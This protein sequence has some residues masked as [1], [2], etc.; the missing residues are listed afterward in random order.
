MVVGR[1]GDELFQERI[2]TREVVGEG[3]EVTRY[4]EEPKLS[5]PHWLRV[6][7]CPVNNNN[8]VGLPLEL[9]IPARPR[10]RGTRTSSQS[11]RGA[12][13]PPDLPSSSSPLAQS[14]SQI[15]VAVSF[16]PHTLHELNR[17]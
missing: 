10:C 15:L 5:S 1:V 16:F 7:D 6:R 4:V 14:R 17:I 3:R 12:K 2:D 9:M 8:G 11:Q 13:D